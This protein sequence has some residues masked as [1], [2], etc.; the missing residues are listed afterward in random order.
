MRRIDRILIIQ[1]AYIGD[2]LLTT[3]LIQAC[4]DHFPEAAIDIMVIPAAGPLVETHPA[5]RQAILYDKRKSQAGCRGFIALARRLR[6]EHYTLV[7]TPHR[8][9]RSALLAWCSRAGIRVGFD[10]SSGAFLLT[11]KVR[12]DRTR[13]EVERNLSLLTVLGILPGPQRPQIFPTPA[14]CA[15][16]DQ[17]LADL[18]EPGQPLIAI[19]P[20]SIWA[21]KRWPA[22][23]FRRLAEQIARAGWS[24]VWIGGAEDRPLCAGI[25]QGLAGRWLNGA[26]EFTFRQSA[27]VIRR[28]ALLVSNDSAPLH[29]ASATGTPTIA[30]FGP[31]VP[32]FGFG[33]LSDR[34]IVVQRDLPCRP[35]SIHGGRTCPI[36]THACMTG[37]TP[38]QVFD[39]IER[40]VTRKNED[41]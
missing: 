21:T 41:E 29:A 25:S 24:I 13:H 1:T 16:V 10:T 2:V 31:T 17:R 34:S 36:G 9:L 18:V 3:G 30:L 38:E 40:M 4:R 37:I 12:Y 19:A 5:L 20:G 33:P 15:V 32:A 8:S 7:L 28:A 11:H 14:D 6:R 39:E 35:C 26:G 27:E 22:A 23:S